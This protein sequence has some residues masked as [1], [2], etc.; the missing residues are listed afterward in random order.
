MEGA[1]DRQ[2]LH[3]GLTEKLPN[4]NRDE[5]VSRNGEYVCE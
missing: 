1:F 2:I 4:I 3:V 5:E